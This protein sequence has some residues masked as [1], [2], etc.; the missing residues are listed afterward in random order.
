MTPRARWSPLKL[1]GTLGNF[2]RDVRSL[3]CQPPPAIAFGLG[4]LGVE[5]R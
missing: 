1:T 5:V 2:G 4:S 3:S